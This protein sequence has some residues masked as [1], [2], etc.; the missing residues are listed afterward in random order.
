M[1][2]LLFMMW[3]LHFLPLPMLGRLANFVGALIFRIAAK[4]RHITLTNLALCLPHL[5]ESERRR[6]AR[7][8]F[9]AYARSVLERSLL[10]WASPKRLQRLIVCDPPFPLE[11]LQSRPTIILCPHFVCLDVA[12][13]AVA[14]RMSGSSIYTSQ[15]S[16]VFDQA[17]RRG[18]SRFHPPTLMSRAE[19]V[20]PIIRAMRRG[21][22][23]FMLPDM[24]FGRRESEFV[25]FFGIPAATLT[26]PARLA[27]MTGA[28][29][30]PV[31]ATFLPDFKGWRVQFYPAWDDFPGPDVLAATARMNRFIE[32][33]VLEAPEQYFWA[34]KRFKTRPEGEPDLYGLAGAGDTLSP[35]ADSESPAV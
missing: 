19:G 18:R 30:M 9:Q 26:A 25:P 5:D 33:R 4:R 10:W 29:V 28:Q 24:D 13:V 21:V 17:L 12:G 7:Q 8:H 31:I 35:D 6:I 1:R 14:M 34:H 22:P 15:R 11:Q 23:F 3:V 16:K 20:K 32:E 2:I 27:G